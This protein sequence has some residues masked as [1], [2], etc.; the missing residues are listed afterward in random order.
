MWSS[1]TAVGGLYNA[2]PRPSLPSILTSTVPGKKARM[3]PNH[4]AVRQPSE[5][6]G[7]LSSPRQGRNN[8]RVETSA[9]A[10]QRGRRPAC[11]RVGAY[12]HAGAL[13]IG[14]GRGEKFCVWRAFNLAIAA[15]LC[16]RRPRRIVAQAR[17]RIGCWMPALAKSRPTCSQVVNVAASAHHAQRSRNHPSA[18][19]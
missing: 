12:R 7:R 8:L 17:H 19:S 5:C 11:R 9:C 10:A 15:A 16:R 13:E 14:A 1:P 2:A 4:D 6:G 3:V 18:K